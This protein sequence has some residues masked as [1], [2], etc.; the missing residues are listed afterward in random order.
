M[1]EGSKE[2]RAMVEPVDASL[3]DLHNLRDLVQK[4]HEGIYVTN[5]AGEILDGNP[6]FL[7]ILGVSSIE[8]ARALRASDVLVDPAEREREMALMDRNGAVRDFELRIRRRDGTIRTVIDSSFASRDR[9]GNMLYRGILVDIT[10]RKLLENQLVEQSVRDPL[11]GCFNRRY[12]RDFEKHCEERQVGWGCIMLDIDYFKEYNDQFG[13]SVG[14]EVL[15]RVSRF[16][17]RSTRA[18]EGVVRFGGDEFCVLLAGSDVENTGRAAD[19]IKHAGARELPVAFSLGWAVRENN[20][21][22]EHTLNHADQNLLE[23]RSLDRSREDR[24]RQ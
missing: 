21:R 11:T 10:D 7:S 13:H 16:L 9:A 6:A 17:M 15:I 5:R 8:E 24:R 3:Q 2:W 22:L 20:E 4:L 23:V 12:L 14:D 19:R 18:E 1:Q